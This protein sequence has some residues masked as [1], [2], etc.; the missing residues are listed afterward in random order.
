MPE[1]LPVPAPAPAPAPAPMANA[2][3]AADDFLTLKQVAK[4]L[5]VTVRYVR[6]LR[7][8]GARLAALREKRAARM[9]TGHRTGEVPPSPTRYNP[10]VR[11][12]AQ[13]TLL[14]VG[15][16]GIVGSEALRAS[17]SLGL[18]PQ[19]LAWTR[20]HPADPQSPPTMEQLESS[21][22]PSGS[23]R[24]RVRRTADG[25]HEV[26]YPRDDHV[27]SVLFIIGAIALVGWFALHRKTRSPA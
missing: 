13:V 14:T 26:S 12:A 22:G 11:R 9:R 19:P 25:H 4:R 18:L 15:I 20:V 21:H 16:V 8:S 17:R 24:G 5:N 7:Q 6:Q 3:P 23:L 10:R 2:L 1:A 27:P